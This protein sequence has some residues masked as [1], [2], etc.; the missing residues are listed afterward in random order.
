MA[1]DNCA[2]TAPDNR[3]AQITINDCEFSV[4]VT[5]ALQN[6]GRY[7]TLAD[8]DVESDDMLRRLPHLG[9][10][11]IKEI[12]DVIR[13]IRFG[14]LSVEQEIVAWAHEHATLIR[15]LMAGEAVI[16]PRERG[17]A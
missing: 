14:T 1:Q 16:V 9:P 12:R 17:N 7:R 15:A 3:L 8:L 11:G 5:N 4:K 6:S 10:K 13:S 2:V